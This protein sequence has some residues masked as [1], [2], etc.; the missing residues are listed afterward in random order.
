MTDHVKKRERRE[1]PVNIT[2]RDVFTKTWI[3]LEAEKANINC[4]ILNRTPK[5]SHAVRPPP[6]NHGPPPNIC[7]PFIFDQ[8]IF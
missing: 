5:F 6:P 7:C 1:G 8:L 2:R 4:V 3:G